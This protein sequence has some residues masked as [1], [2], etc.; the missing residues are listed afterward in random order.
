MNKISN[1]AL[2]FSLLPACE[3]V[4]QPQLRNSYSYPPIKSQAWLGQEVPAASYYKFSHTQVC[5]EITKAVLDTER[6]P[7]DSCIY[8]TDSRTLLEILGF[9]G[10]WGQL[11]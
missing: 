4:R 11:P 8:N 3:A 1:V 6:K 5:R 9:L 7:S 10:F 2:G